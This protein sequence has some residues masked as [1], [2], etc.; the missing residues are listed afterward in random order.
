MSNPT[1]ILFV[2]LGNIVRSPL[3]ENLFRH[4]AIKKGSEKEFELDS[5]GTSAWHVGEPPDSRMRRTAAAHGLN[6][7]GSAR[8]FIR[9]DFE[10]FDLIIA[11]D[12]QNRADLIA[13]AQNPEHHVKVRMMREF[14]PEAG[15]GDGVPDP[16]YGGL[17]GFEKTY[18][19]VERSVRGL[20]EAIEAGEL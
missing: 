14:D 15:E 13:L 20:M 16:Y 17:E 18:T 3:A 12:S 4:L 19:I 2:C 10:R 11:M 6:Y 9:Q 7:D 8:Q 5:A 1:S